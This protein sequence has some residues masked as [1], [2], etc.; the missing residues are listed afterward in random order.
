MFHPRA[1]RYYFR[2]LLLTLCLIVAAIIPGKADPSL[3]NTSSAV[4]LIAGFALVAFIS[5]LIFFNGFFS[6]GEK[7]V[8]MTL[9]ALGVKM[10]LSFLLA[11]LFFLVLKN[12]ATG[13]LILFFVIYLAITVYVIL[14]FTSVLKKKSD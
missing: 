8:F 13:S 12:D 11:L 9:I 7:S 3:Y 14:T 6:G 4:L 5:L 2:L 10:L 1:I